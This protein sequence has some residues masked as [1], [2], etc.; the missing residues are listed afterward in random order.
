MYR[1]RLSTVHST[2]TARC[3]QLSAG[4]A[5]CINVYA[6]QRADRLYLAAMY[7][8]PSGDDIAQLHEAHFYVSGTQVAEYQPLQAVD[9]ET[10]D[11]RINRDGSV[12]DLKY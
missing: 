1:P 7:W 3:M 4:R 12:S 10:F 8:T 2:V 6:N 5:V 9:W 11:I